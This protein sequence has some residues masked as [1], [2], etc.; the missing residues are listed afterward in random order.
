MPFPEYKNKIEA[1]LEFEFAFYDATAKFISQ[2][3]TQTPLSREFK[4][5]IS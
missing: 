1:L 4:K 5:N 3:F 2:Y